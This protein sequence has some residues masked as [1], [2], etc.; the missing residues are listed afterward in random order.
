MAMTQ[1]E[2]NRRK[3]MIPRNPV[4]GMAQYSSQTSVGV[5]MDVSNPV[6]RPLHS[7][8][9]YLAE[10]TIET[11]KTAKRIQAVYCY[12]EHDSTVQ[13]IVER[14]LDSGKKP[15]K[16]TIKILLETSG[17]RV[18]DKM[19]KIKEYPI[20]NTIKPKQDGKR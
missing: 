2:R 11:T 7:K 8:G 4:E 19:E 13:Q 15:T 17:E 1:K 16:I 5:V 6:L 3:G 18:S 20:T 12:G 9:L 14:V 10:Y